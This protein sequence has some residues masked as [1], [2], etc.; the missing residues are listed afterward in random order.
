MMGGGLDVMTPPFQMKPGVCRS[1]QN[2]ECSMFGGYRR[3]AGY[4][5]RDGRA[6]PSDASYSLL[7]ATSITGG[8]VGDTLTGSTSGA[9]G[10]IIAITATYFVLTATSGT[11]IAENLNVGAGTIAVSTGAASAGAP[12]VKLSAQYKNLAAD[13]YRALIGA[14][15]GSGKV[16]GVFYYNDV[17]YGFRNNAGSTAAALYKSSG[18]GWVLV[19]LGRELNFTSGGTYQVAVGDTIT[20]AISGAT[21]VITGVALESGTYAAGTAVGHYTFASQTGTFQAENLN[22]GINLDVATIA[23]N[24]S[25]ITLTKDGRYEFVLYNFTGSTNTK[26]VYGCDGVN[27]GFE[28]DGTTY[29]P[30]N[31]GMAVDKPQHVTAHL[32]HLFFSFF[33]SVQ[34]SSTGFPYQWAPVTGAAELAMGDTVTGFMAQ[35]AGTTA[36]ALAIFTAGRLSILYGTGSTD[37]QLLPYRDSIGAFAYTAQDLA[38][39]MF[40]DLQ[41]VTNLE[42]VQAFG[43]FSY[44]VLSNPVKSM[45]SGWRNGVV[46]SSLCRDLSQYRIFF[47]NNYGL[48]FTVLGKKVIGIMPVLFP[49]TVRCTFSGMD[50]SGNEVSFFGTDSGYVMQMDKGTSFDGA[51]IEAYINLSYNFSRGPRTN[52]KY[53]DAVLEVSGAGYAEF[54]FGYSLGYGASNIIQPASQLVVTNFSSVFWDAFTW[55]AFTWDGVT[56]GPSSLE[57]DGE[58]ENISFGV[59]SIGDYFEPYTLTGGLMHYSPRREMR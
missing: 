10:K 50:S 41:G 7:A 58:A 56:L 9:T 43:N 29:I 19:S 59:T 45:L 20:G 2:F 37:W 54:N 53:R 49:D 27:R 18:S 51:D 30:I 32:Y 11:F 38:S 44:A 3:I 47:T 40:L 52:K 15:P 26:K 13:Y 35:A 23:G 6:K 21:A 36:A 48:Y 57:L 4:E 28:F 22:V 5:R 39:T 14:I 55:D 24:S 17:L 25:A 8:A 16:L 12:S 42:T 33:G 31:T 46:A 34:H 1:A